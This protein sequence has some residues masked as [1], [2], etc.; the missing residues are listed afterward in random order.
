MVI[1]CHYHLE[2]SILSL[3]GLLR[4]M[5]ASGVHKTALMGSIAGPIP[6]PPAVLVSVLQHLLEKP[7]LRRIGKALV[8]NFTERGEIKVLGKA[9]RIETDPDNEAVFRA[10]DA[11]PGRFLGWIFVNP[12]GNR[13]QV[14]EFDKFKDRKGFAGV[15]AHPFWHHFDPV[16]LVPVA[17]KLARTGKPLLVHLG[18]GAQG[19]F[20]ALLARVPGLK[21]ILAHAGF[22]CY[23]DT[24][25][26]IRGLGNVYLDLSQTIYTSERATRKAMDALGPDRLLFGTDGPYG[27]HTPEGRYDY[28][29][30][31]RRLQRLFPDG[32]VLDR[33]MGGN[34]EKLAGLG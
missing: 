4:E 1:D 19:D 12:H 10:V 2:E 26:R 30:I 21:L 16:E 5:D 31:K 17:E 29:F 3:D 24:W 14:A 20:P 7:V 22:P 34:F 8:A 6:D 13:D 9:Y 33:V 28:G 11:H 27:F 25:K 23:G 15:K 18:F 32:R